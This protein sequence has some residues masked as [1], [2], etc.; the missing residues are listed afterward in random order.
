MS[1]FMILRVG[2]ASISLAVFVDAEAQ[3]STPPRATADYVNAIGIGLSYGE[4]NQKDADFW[5]W[6]ADYSRWLNSRWIAG[7]TLT[8]DKE[9]ER[10]VDRP[11]KVVRSYSVLGTV[12]YN[13]TEKFSLTTGLGL[14]VAN[15]DNNSGTMKFKSGDVS[16]GLALGYTTLLS[17]R[18]SLG[19]SL[20]YEYN[21]SNNETSVSADVTLGRSF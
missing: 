4:H 8:W 7:V 3:I 18:Y 21:I 1:D 2:I 10:F 11:D 17:E 15:D 13:L 5:G 14:E 20:S 19:A 16:T 12:S 9:T 6:S